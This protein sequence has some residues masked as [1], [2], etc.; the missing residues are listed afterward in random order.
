MPFNPSNLCEFGQCIGGICGAS[1]RGS[2]GVPD[3]V[4]GFCVGFCNP[5]TGDYDYSGTCGIE[6]SGTCNPITGA[7]EEATTSTTSTTPVTTTT[8]TS[9]PRT[10]IVTSGTGLPVDIPDNG[11]VEVS[12]PIELE[13]GCGCTVA[14][15]A[16]AI[17]VDHTN[18]GDLGMFL[19]SPDNTGI[20]FLVDQ[21]PSTANLVA[22]NKITFDDS[23][24][25]ALDPR[26]L[27]G[28]LGDNDPIPAGTYFARDPF[29][30]GKLNG[31]VLPSEGN[32][33]FSVFDNVPAGNIGTIESVELTITCAE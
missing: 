26:T 18:V 22:G 14:N 21:P 7:C 8:T 9:C 16:I 2:I 11:R 13:E 33:R 20:V 12:I 1:G 4:G 30:L 10:V 17:G 29:G 19:T 27:G 24:D 23:V 15:V 25:G 5:A 3:G 31:K 6:E 28:G 32:W